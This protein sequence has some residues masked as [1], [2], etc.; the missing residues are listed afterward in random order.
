MYIRWAQT[1]EMDAT[2]Y[3]AVNR[4]PEACE[5]CEALHREWGKLPKVSQRL[6]IKDLR[7]HYLQWQRNNQKKHPTVITPVRKMF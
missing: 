5:A 2:L 4:P 1:V 3:Y 6:N 7:A